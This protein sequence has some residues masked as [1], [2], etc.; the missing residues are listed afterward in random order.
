MSKINQNEQNLAQ[1]IWETV[2]SKSTDG[3]S[4]KSMLISGIK[5]N[6]LTSISNVM[7]GIVSLIKEDKAYQVAY[8]KTYFDLYNKIFTL[9]MEQLEK[10]DVS[11]GDRD[12]FCNLLGKL[13]DNL[14]VDKKSID[15]HHFRLQEKAW[16]VLGKIGTAAVLISGA[17]FGTKYLKDK[18]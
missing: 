16:D 15:E 6:S 4:I 2:K 10:P 7:G 17:F 13:S 5:E 18:Y 8:S 11:D 12:R 9:C 3:D 14:N 1:E